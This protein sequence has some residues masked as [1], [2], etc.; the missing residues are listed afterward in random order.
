M[1]SNDKEL[2]AAWKSYNIFTK[3]DEDGGISLKALLS[4][5]VVMI[6]QHGIKNRD[7]I[8]SQVNEA[9]KRMGN[10]APQDFEDVVT[11]GIDPI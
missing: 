1:D 11:F 10:I 5:Y 2:E 7:W 8:L 6:S 3:L 9:H 4:L